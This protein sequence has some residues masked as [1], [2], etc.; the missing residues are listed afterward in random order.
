MFLVISRREL[1]FYHCCVTHI[2]E[3]DFAAKGVGSQI[4]LID[5][6]VTIRHEEF[7]ENIL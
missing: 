3:R 7:E 4:I 1:D 6:R 2:V 5:V